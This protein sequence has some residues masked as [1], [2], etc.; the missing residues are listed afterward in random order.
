MKKHNFDIIIP[1]Y[2]EGYGIIKLLKL[3]KIKLKENNFN[4]ILCYDSKED[5]VFTFIKEIKN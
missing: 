1:I 4:V 2:N 3:I 5:N